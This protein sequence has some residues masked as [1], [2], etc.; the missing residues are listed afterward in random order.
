MVK[1]PTCKV[2]ITAV[3]KN[4]LYIWRPKNGDGVEQRCTSAESGTLEPA[5]IADAKTD[6][7]AVLLHLRMGHLN[8]QDMQRLRTRSMNFNLQAGSVLPF[9]EPCVLA[10]STNKPYH[11]DSKNLEYVMQRITVDILGP[12]PTSPAGKRYA[13]DIGNAKS[14]RMWTYPLAFKSDADGLR[15]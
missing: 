4:R 2:I 8:F 9:C 11:Q 15:M 1:D 7:L 12:D 10:K 13:L 3:K 5:L 6:D 14:G